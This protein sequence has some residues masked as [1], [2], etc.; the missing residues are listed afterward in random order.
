MARFTSIA[1]FAYV[2]RNADPI[3]QYAMHGRD[4]E[5]QA[6]VRLQLLMLNGSYISE[7]SEDLITDQWG[8]QRRI[9][10]GYK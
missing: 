2:G 8:F 3:W 4:C 1:L 7:M 5:A 9:F 6:K 10:R